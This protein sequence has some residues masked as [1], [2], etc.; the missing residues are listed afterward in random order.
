MCKCK[1]LSTP[2]DPA[3]GCEACSGGWTGGDCSADENECEGNNT[4]GSHASCT[5]EP[6]TYS[7]HCAEGFYRVNDICKRER[8]CLFCKSVNGVHFTVTLIMRLPCNYGKVPKLF[9]SNIPNAK[10]LSL[11]VL[12]F[13]SLGGDL[14]G[15]GLC[16]GHAL[17]LPLSVII[18]FLTRFNKI[19]T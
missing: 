4:C 16:V 6:G 12:L 17:C 8:S 10:L 5:N 11:F 18:R 2:C 1:S 3:T 19:A 14:N 15:D 13:P 7:C 9:C